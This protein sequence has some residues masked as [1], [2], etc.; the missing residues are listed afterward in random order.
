MNCEPGSTPGSQKNLSNMRKTIPILLLT[1]AFTVI[2]LGQSAGPR[3]IYLKLDE[4]CS[5]CSDAKKIFLGKITRLINI[6]KN[7]GW[8]GA[9]FDVEFRVLK[10]FRGHTA[11]TQRFRARGQG[12]LFYMLPDVGDEVIFCKDRW[13][14]RLT[15]D[16]AESGFSRK[17]TI[18][19]VAASELNDSR[20]IEGRVTR[21][22]HSPYTD[23]AGVKTDYNKY[24]EAPGVT[25]EAVGPGGKKFHTRTDDDGHYKFESLPYGN[26]KVY[27]LVEKN[28]AWELSHGG[29]TF[30]KAKVQLLRTERCGEHQVDF[31]L[32]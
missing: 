28:A 24:I 7:S 10:T 21:E 3:E 5:E 32:V 16:P 14:R 29:G 1:L 25:I 2:G 6:K 20:R 26:Y 9:E 31:V 22:I 27:P 11:K 12:T 18:A 17:K 23:A 8:P 4:Y 30:E 13:S 19:M 15:D